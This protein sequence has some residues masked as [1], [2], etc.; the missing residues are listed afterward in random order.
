MPVRVCYRSPGEVKPCLLDFSS[1][2]LAEYFSL[3]VRA[4][5]RSAPESRAT[6]V[7]TFPD[8]DVRSGTPAAATG[9]KGVS[10]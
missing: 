1:P 3:G 7:E 4:G 5:V 2:T 10:A 8:C 6:A 9:P